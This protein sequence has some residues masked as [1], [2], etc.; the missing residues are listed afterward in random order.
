M[1]KPTFDSF[2]KK[3]INKCEKGDNCQLLRKAYN[4]AE[5]I[6]GNKIHRSGIE[7]FEHSLELAQT[8][9]E[10][11]IDC[12]TVCAAILHDTL[13][14]VKPSDLKKA[15]FSTRIIK[16]VQT[17]YYL[18][19]ISPH[20]HQ[21]DLEKILT[22][23]SDNIRS[24]FIRIAHQLIDIRHLD[25][26]DPPTAH[27]IA[28][29]SLLLYSAIAGRLS[30]NRIRR[31]IED[32]CFQ[33]IYP[34]PYQK[35]KNLYQKTNE[36]DQTCLQQIQHLINNFLKKEKITFQLQSRLKGIYST[37]RKIVLKKKKYDELYDRLAIRILVPKISHCY[38]VLGILHQHFTPIPG[39]LKDY[40]GIPKPNGYQAIHTV[41]YPRNGM[42][43][44]PIEIQIRTEAMHQ[45]AEYGI[46]AHWNYKTRQKIADSVYHQV[47]TLKN[48][49]VLKSEYNNPQEFVKSLNNYFSGKYI[50]IFNNES[51]ILHLPRQATALDAAF[52][53]YGDKAFRTQKIKINGR[54]QPLNTP[55]FDGDTIEITSANKITFQKNWLNKIHTKF[56]KKLFHDYILNCTILKNTQNRYSKKPKKQP[57]LSKFNHI[58]K[59]TS[60]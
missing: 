8:I 15:G 30:M 57:K 43:I 52:I 20:N 36:S 38:Q 3:L 27:R 53:I 2:Q 42:S 58:L 50:V 24:W 41:I 31:E 34:Q 54:F 9:T 32:T 26:F 51:K 19:R 13:I 39:R 4:F 44:Y 22:V 25:R 55:L 7:Y 40:I 49:L 28:Q 12:D 45:Q 46:A 48:L 1:P 6:L 33:Y 23:I 17:A 47:N 35:I 56:V 29:E 10:M 16:I 21:H 59:N 60:F 14:F 18:R 5:K 37:Y 11:K